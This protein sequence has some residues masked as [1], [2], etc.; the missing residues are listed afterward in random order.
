MG[1]P[2]KIAK[3]AAAPVLS[4]TTGTTNVITVDSTT[5]MTQGMRF[6][7]ASTVGGLTGGTTYFVNDVLNTTTFTALVSSVEV[8]P[9]VSPT[10]STTT[11][12]TVQLS[13]NT[14]NTGY[15][16]ASGYGIVGGNTAIYG[17]QCLVSVA[18][19]ATGTG[20]IWVANG[21]DQM[22]GSADAD[23]TNLTNVGDTVSVEYTT[24]GDNTVMTQQ[25]G[26]VG[27]IDVVTVAVANTKVTGNIVGASGT[28]TNLIVD[29][30]VW[31]D[32]AIGGLAAN[33]TYFVKNVA[34]ADAYT[35]SASQLVDGTAGAE[36]Q[37]ED[38]TTAVTSTQEVI[39]L[40]TSNAGSAVQDSAWI[41]ATD[42]AGFIVRQKG[43]FKYLCQDASGSSAICTT[44]NLAN[45][46]LIANTFSLLSTDVGAAT[47]NLLS[48]SDH[49]GTEFGADA[50]LANG[51][52]VFTTF[53]SAEAASP[54]TGVPYEVVTVNK[55]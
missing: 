48:F 49:T 10:L 8:Q 21:S 46:A 29:K 51:D 6:I 15:T 41:Q 38:E 4:D 45:A 25:L 43:K 3:V 12:G 42:S 35:V 7:P 26:L 22:Y 24:G 19:G 39:T 53:G 33:T 1:R 27:S 17:D 54:S 13:V 44:S 18:I 9:Q 50:T 36:V 40:D 52:P 34:N 2:L 20:T 14:V 5:G 47:E 11:G 30:P 28:A 32:I 31:F 16:N 23:F 55:A 37:L